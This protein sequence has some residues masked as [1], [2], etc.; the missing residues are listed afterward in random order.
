MR[1]NKGGTK[2]TNAGLSRGHQRVPQIKLQDQQRKHKILIPMELS[3]E[4]SKK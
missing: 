2:T 4:V 3:S 1:K